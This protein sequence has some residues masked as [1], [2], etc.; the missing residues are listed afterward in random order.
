MSKDIDDVSND[1]G[2]M[3]ISE[4]VS[5]ACA[6]CGKECDSLKSCAACKMV[7]YCNRDCQIAHRSQHKKECRRRAAELHDEKLFKQPPP[8]DD[9]PICFLLLPTLLSGS[10]YQSCCGK[11]ICSGCIH[12]MD[13]IC[14]FCR[15]PT[16]KSDGKYIEQIMK[17]VD[18]GDAQGIASLGYYYSNGMYGL[19]QDHAKALKHWRRAAELGGSKIRIDHFDK[20]VCVACCGRCYTDAVALVI[21]LYIR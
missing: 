8:L 11:N 13:K 6:N 21:E 14:P 18:A 3:G 15:T 16:P 2:R 9:C 10:R 4:N 5:D 17:R 7:K 1:I 20:V 19:P 12:A